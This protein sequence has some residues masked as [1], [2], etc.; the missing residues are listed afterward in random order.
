ML[1][2]GF[3]DGEQVFWPN[4]DGNRSWPWPDMVLGHING[5]VEGV[6]RGEG[7]ENG[8]ER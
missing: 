8:L 4:S 2:E 3:C 6:R 5:F 1:S 7:D